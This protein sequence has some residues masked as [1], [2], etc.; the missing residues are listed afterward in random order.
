MARIRFEVERGYTKTPNEIFSMRELT[1]NTRF[2]FLYMLSVHP[3]HELSA[4]E[5]GKVVGLNRDTVTKALNDL[6]KAGLVR[7]KRRQVHPRRPPV[8]GW[9]CAWPSFLDD[10]SSSS[11]PKRK[12]SAAEETGCGST[13]LREEPAAEIFRSGSFGQRKDSAAYKDS[14]KRGSSTAT[15][16]EDKTKKMPDKTPPAPTEEAPRVLRNFNGYRPPAEPPEKPVAKPG[17]ARTSPP[18][19]DPDFDRAWELYGHKV[20]KLAAQRKWKAALKFA[21]AETI[22]AAIP[23][24]VK[25]TPDTKYRAHFAT[26]LHGQRW[27]D[28]I[29]PPKKGYQGRAGADAR[30]RHE[31]EDLAKHWPVPRLMRYGP[32]MMNREGCYAWYWH[33][34]RDQADW[35]LEQL[36][37]FGNTPDDARVLSEAFACGPREGWAEILAAVNID[38]ETDR[39]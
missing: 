32:F 2:V 14:S 9:D 18:T 34:N 13:P 37:E 33:W 30:P 28:E 17:K 39:P 1:A 6:A 38:I 20:Q 36:V 5:I 27:N 10:D 21:D 23:A 25:S 31:Y 12:F 15:S 11:A 24:Y 35:S 22:I 4:E 26:W 29:E 7:S 19:D 8:R 16:Q 3:D